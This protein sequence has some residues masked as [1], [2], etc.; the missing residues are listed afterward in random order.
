MTTPTIAE[1]LE[2]L[3]CMLEQMRPH[4]VLEGIRSALEAAAKEQA[5]WEA[6]EGFT[7]HVE[8]EPPGGHAIYHS[9]VLEDETVTPV[10]GRYFEGD[11]RSEAL[12]AAAKWIREQAK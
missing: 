10:G 6:I 12:A 7:P 3:D 8:L 1:A 2:A 9:I 5:D 4:A 11:T